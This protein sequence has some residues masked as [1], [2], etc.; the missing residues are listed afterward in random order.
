MSA[1]EPAAAKGYYVDLGERQ[2]L[3]LGDILEVFRVQP[4]LN[5][6]TGDASNFVRIHLGDLKII[7]LGEYSSIGRVQGLADPKDL[8][9]LDHSTFMLGDIVEVK[10]SLPFDGRT[11]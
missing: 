8:P 3:K 7:L 1:S 9:V 6:V 10:S 5:G 11:P 4:V 2:G